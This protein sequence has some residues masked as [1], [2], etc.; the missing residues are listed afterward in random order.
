MGISAVGGNACGETVSTGADYQPLL[1]IGEFDF[2]DHAFGRRRR[3]AR[4]ALHPDLAEPAPGCF[5][6][7][8]VRGGNGGLAPSRRH[9]A[10]ARSATSLS[11]G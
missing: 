7:A 8:E 10:A 11:P 1:P 4:C 6:F 2:A 5:T 9:E 3:R